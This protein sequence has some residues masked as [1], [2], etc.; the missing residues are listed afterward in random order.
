MSP[1]IHIF[2]PALQQ[3]TGCQI[4]RVEGTTVGEGLNSLVEQFPGA[5]N[6]IF[7]IRGQLL[8]YVFVYINAESVQKA[9]LS[10]P[11]TSVD[12]LLLAFM[13]TGG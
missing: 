1:E 2:Y 4:V 5:E 8:E 6:W 10:D 9:R 11:L 3:I 7:D 13:V 12:K